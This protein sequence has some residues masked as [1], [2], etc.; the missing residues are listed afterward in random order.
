MNDAKRMTPLHEERM[1]CECY[2]KSVNIGKA[3]LLQI[4][5]L[6][7]FLFFLVSTNH[8]TK[9]SAWPTTVTLTLDNNSI[10]YFAFHFFSSSKW[11]LSTT[12]QVFLNFL[13]LSPFLL[14]T[15]RKKEEEEGDLVVVVI[16]VGV[17]KSC[18]FFHPTCAYVGG[19]NQTESSIRVW[20]NEK[21]FI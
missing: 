2:T 16:V 11:Q 20:M 10:N 4:P 21:D 6:T 3:L 14:F 19:F 18:T 5:N 15:D 9:K 12:Y 8:A 13:S 1:R 17:V 7:S